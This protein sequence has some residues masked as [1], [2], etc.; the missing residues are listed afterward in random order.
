MPLAA[1]PDMYRQIAGTGIQ[2]H[3]GI[4]MRRVRGLQLC[5]KRAKASEVPFGSATG[6]RER[7]AR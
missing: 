1:R 4:G 5:L 6:H 7:A 2:L 3:G